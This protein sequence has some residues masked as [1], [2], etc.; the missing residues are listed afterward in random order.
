MDK[1]ILFVKSDI[2]NVKSERNKN[3]VSFHKQQ[4]LSFNKT[5]LEQVNIRPG[6]YASFA[7]IDKSRRVLTIEVRNNKIPWE[8]SVWYKITN[9]KVSK[10]NK[11]CY[12]RTTNLLHNFDLVLYGAFEYKVSKFLDSLLIEIYY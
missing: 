1:N 9:P 8:K 6:M 2:Q 3:L 7:F 10:H 5:T 4:V 12:I 11:Y